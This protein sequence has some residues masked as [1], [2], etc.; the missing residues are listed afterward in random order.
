M[1]KSGDSELRTSFGVT[2]SAQFSSRMNPA[3][4]VVAAKM[5]G[6]FQTWFG[7]RTPNFMNSVITPVE[8]RACTGDIGEMRSCGEFHI[9]FYKQA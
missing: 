5:R 8:S 3:F 4:F 1:S 2:A 6:K 7:G 9:F